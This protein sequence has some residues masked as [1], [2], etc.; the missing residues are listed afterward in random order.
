[1]LAFKRIF[2][3]DRNIVIGAIHFPPLPGYPAFPGIKRA[4]VNASRDLNA[5]KRGGVDGVIFEN[6]YDQPHVIKAETGTAV[7]MTYLGERINRSA[8]IPVGVSTLWNDFETSLV[9]AKLL[10]LDFIRIPVFVDT[11][12]A[13]CGVIRGNPREAVAYRRKMKAQNVALFTDIHVK[14]AKLIS[15]L[16]LAQSAKR[17]IAAGSDALIITGEWTGDAPDVKDLRDVRL[18]V[19]N[20]PIIVGS[21]ADDRNIRTLMRYANGVIVSTSLKR[22]VRKPS[23]VNVK[24]YSQR[25]DIKKVRRFVKVVASK[26]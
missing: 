18:A 11:V 23:E 14:H 4:E 15:R 10:G 22:G 8:G 21:G 9:I 5:F 2:G 6:N 20:F 1:M 26:N 19:G 16:S 13:S 12:R 24:A 3:K 7:A 17:S 25:V